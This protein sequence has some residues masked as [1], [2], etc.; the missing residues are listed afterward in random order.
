MPKVCAFAR[1]DNICLA[2]PMSWPKQF[3][4]LKQGNTKTK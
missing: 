4:K 3:K 2:P 1:A